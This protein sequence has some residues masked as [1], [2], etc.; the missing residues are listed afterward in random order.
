[1]DILTNLGISDD[2]ILESEEN[3]NSIAL[4]RKEAPLFNPEFSYSGSSYIIKVY[5]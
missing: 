3:I 2:T 5:K 1:M 4:E